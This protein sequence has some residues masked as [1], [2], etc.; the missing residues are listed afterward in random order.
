MSGGEVSDKRTF[1]DDTI[2]LGTS[3]T[4]KINKGV[5][6]WP[7][8]FELQPS[9]AES[10]EGMASTWVVYHLN[11]SVARPGWNAK[12]ITKHV[13]VRIVRT[14][15]AEQMG[16]SRSRVRLSNGKMRPE[17]GRL[18]RLARLIKTS[19]QTRSATPYRYPRMRWFLAPP[20]S[21]TSSCRLCGKGSHWARW[22]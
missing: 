2:T 7:F 20:S 3:G 16:S 15:G 22:T 21:Q 9:M 17:V 1:F 19:G 11:A 13:H 5:L 18:T 12:D 10:V 4:H 14:L 8:E 6:E